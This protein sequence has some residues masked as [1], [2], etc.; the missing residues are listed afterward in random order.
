MTKRCILPTTAV[1][2]ELLDIPWDTGKEMIWLW[3]RQ[4]FPVNRAGFPH[5]DAL[6]LMEHFHRTDHEHMRLDLF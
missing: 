1:S 6:H 5:S 2:P 3:T 4:D